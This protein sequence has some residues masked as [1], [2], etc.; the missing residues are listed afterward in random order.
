MPIPAEELF[1]EKGERV[2]PGAGYDALRR[3]EGGALSIG[4]GNGGKM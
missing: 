3:N 4:A 2:F 1:A